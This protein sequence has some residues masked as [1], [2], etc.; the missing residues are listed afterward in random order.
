[1]RRHPGIQV[2]TGAIAS[3]VVDQ[4]KEF[5]SGKLKEG[6]IAHLRREFNSIEKIQIRL[7]IKKAAKQAMH[8]YET[9]IP[10]LDR[11]GITDLVD[12]GA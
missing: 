4:S 2:V 6:K 7:R 12:K 5:I 8:G 1:M 3:V 10:G 11:E 9:T